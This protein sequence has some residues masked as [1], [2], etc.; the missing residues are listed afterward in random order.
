MVGFLNMV[1]R[2]N[3]TTVVGADHV[4]MLEHDIGLSGVKIKVR[5]NRIVDFTDNS[6]KYYTAHDFILERK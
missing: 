4:R 6:I 1:L 3:I 2:Q 5:D